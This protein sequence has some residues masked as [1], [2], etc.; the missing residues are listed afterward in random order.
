MAL[1]GVA[2]FVKA[3]ASISYAFKRSIEA[4]REVVK[5]NFSGSVRRAFHK[6][7][8]ADVY[9]ANTELLTGGELDD[10]H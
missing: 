8:R 7:T 10:S 4:A 6:F 3:K 2:T 9:S 1:V 5:R